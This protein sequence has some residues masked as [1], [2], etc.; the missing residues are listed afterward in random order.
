MKT[1]RKNVSQLKERIFLTDGGL[2]TTLVFEH[3]FNLPE[4]ASFTL[5]K[6]KR[7]RKAMYDYYLPYIDLA[8]QNQFGFILEGSTWR[9]SKDWGEK[10]G[11][12]T[13]DLEKANLDGIELLAKLRKTHENDTTPMLISGCIGPRGDGYRPAAKMNPWEAQ[14]YHTTQIQTLSTTEADLVSAF[15]INY[16]EEA[17]GITRAAQQFDIPVVISFTLE[18]DGR[19]PS[20]Q[21]LGAAIEEVDQKTQNGPAYYMI[22]CAHPSHFKHVLLT[23]A[24]W[25]ERIHAIRA[26]ASC[27]SHAEL[28]ESNELDSGNPAE[29]GRDYIDLIELLPNLTVFGGCCGTDIRHLREICEKLSASA[30]GKISAA[31]A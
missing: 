17:I 29:L 16:A 18:T 20:G 26:N 24:A 21:P 15:T 1:Y 5:L 14:Q 22:N 13:R 23:N 8:K 28:D 10:L 12:N 19:L 4:F 7:G 3:G 27:K 31:C 2:E 30:A 11:Y 25:K 6:E 9:A